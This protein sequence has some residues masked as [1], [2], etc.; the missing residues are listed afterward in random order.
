MTNKVVLNGGPPCFF[1][2]NRRFCGRAERWGGHGV[3][4]DFISL[5]ALL[6]SQ[7]PLCPVHRRLDQLDQLELTIAENSCVA[8]SLHEREALIDIL[9][10]ALSDK[11]HESRSD[12]A[13]E[14]QEYV[15]S[16]NAAIAKA[17][18]DQR[19]ATLRE[20]YQI[21]NIAGAIGERLAIAE[22]EALKEKGDS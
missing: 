20:C 9:D 3:M 19:I 13:T 21:E 11:S 18:S 15:N 17:K 6:E 8:C 10:K 14:L 2:E 7:F 1:V 4:H 22:R 5:H 12:S 16:F